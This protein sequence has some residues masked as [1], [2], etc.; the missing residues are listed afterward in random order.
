M[1]I[2]IKQILS[3]ASWLFYQER[4]RKTST[5][6]FTQKRLNPYSP[7][8][9]IFFIIFVLSLIFREIFK[10]IQSMYTENPFKWE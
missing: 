10:I 1:K 4:S 8:A 5:N 2:N 6:T 9:Y 7:F 3:K